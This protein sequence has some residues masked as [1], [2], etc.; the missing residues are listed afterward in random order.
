M[1]PKWRPPLGLVIFAILSVVT[2]LP[3]VGLF[4]F[5]LYDNQLIRQTEQELIAQGAVLSA[6]FADEVARARTHGPLVLGVAEAPAETG[7]EPYH[8]VIA[9]L[10]LANDEPRGPRPEPVE[11]AGPTDPV[12]TAIGQDL[13]RLAVETQKTTLTGFRFLDP[14]GVVIGGREE[15]GQSLA[16]IEEV[17]AA[18]DGHYRSVLRQRI[19]NHPEPPLASIS[20]GAHVRVFAAMPVFVAGHVAGAVYLSRTPN[21]VLESLYAERRTVLIAALTILMV[22]LVIGYVFLRTLTRPI[23][24]LIRRTEQI[25]RGDRDAVRPLTHHGTREIAHLAQSF[26][27]MAQNLFDRSDYIATFTAHVSHELK[28]PLTSIQGA[29]ELLRDNGDAMSEPERSKFLGNIVSD[30]ERLTALVRRLRDLAKADNPELGGKASVGAVVALLRQNTGILGFEAT[31]EPEAEIAMSEENAGIVLAHLAD[32]AAQH[33]ASGIRI[34]VVPAE[35][36]VVSITVADDG[37]GISE[38]NRS[39]IFD[40]HF[41]TRRE[42]GGTGMGLSIVDSLLRAHGGSIRL[43]PT[44]AGSAFE[45]SIPRA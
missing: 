3:L 24:E 23:H 5:R 2:A 34:H 32:N 29:A 43:L 21:N 31:G 25:Q 41:T 17:R 7:A 40:P 45:I 12:W 33:G 30:T 22:T 10:D 4:L 11:P 1:K 44:D 14:E 16:G 9:T 37:A 38:G 20:R 8:P 15:V 36:G 28:S 19:P 35:T 18:L 27:D 39:R 13:T 42:S 26:L 6:V